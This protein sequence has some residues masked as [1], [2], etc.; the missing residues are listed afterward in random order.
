M[1]TGHKSQSLHFSFEWLLLFV[2]LICAWFV[3][4][5]F[6]FFILVLVC[7]NFVRKVVIDV[8]NVTKLQNLIDEAKN[9]V[10]FGG[11]GVSTA[12][13]IKDFRG[14]NGLYNKNELID[15]MPPEYMLSS[16]LFYSKPD[17]FYEYY[18][19]N[20]NCTEAKPNIVHKYLANLEKCGKL[21]AVVTQNIDGL[22][23]KAGSKNVLEIH[24]TTYKNHCTECGKEYSANYVF[25]SIGV[26][27]CS[28]GGII[29]P[30]VVLYGEMLPEAFETATRYIY[31]A[32]LLIVAGT[33]L[34]VEPAASL[35]RIFGGENLVIIYDAPTPYDD[36]ARLVIHDNMVNVFEKLNEN[37]KR[38]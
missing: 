2:V 14:K 20:M 25:N 29:K 16:A 5:F 33:S 38:D 7:Y 23:Q 9:I 11:A 6:N 19:E 15:G 36:V 4:V 3:L 8:N 32:D 30:D 17:V 35:V 28:C 26:P 1:Q 22:H 27:K 18:K 10:F 12:S 21:S 31:L 13:G 34:T 24:G 37:I